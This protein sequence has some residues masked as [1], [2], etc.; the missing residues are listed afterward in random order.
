MTILFQWIFLLALTLGGL[1]ARA[2]EW[3]HAPAYDKALA[4]NVLE[5]SVYFL[6]LYRHLGRAS[7]CLFRTPLPSFLATSNHSRCYS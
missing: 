4:A 7:S 3:R 2:Q 6:P 5:R 1:A